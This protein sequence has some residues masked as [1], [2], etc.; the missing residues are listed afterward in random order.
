VSDHCPILVQIEREVRIPQRQPRRQYKILWERESDLAERV[1]AA[2]EDAGQK[3]DLADIMKGL[4][5]VMDTLQ[6]WSKRRFGN[7]LKEL[8]KARKRLELLK[9][10][11]ADQREIRQ[12]SDQLQELLYR[13]ELLWLQR[14]RVTWLKEGDRNT[15]FFHQRAV[16][17]A[18][19]NKIK[20]LKDSE[21]VWQ[22][23]PTDMERMATSY[24]QEL[25]T[26]DP[27]LNSDDLIAM[28]PEKVTEAMNMDLCKDFTEEEISD[29]L[30]QIGPLKAPGVD[31]FPARF[32]QR[33]WSTLKVEVIN[34]VRLFF[35]HRSYAP[36]CE[37]DGHCVDT[38]N[39]PT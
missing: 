15:K 8:G 30:F 31:G 21:G 39:G 20:R 37:R 2:W 26:R 10:N 9:I 5:G 17:R 1:A 29:A 28:I 24:F 11:N 22:D 23:S 4:D 19:K 36:W 32:Y 16:W 34:A 18:R 33:N 38:E 14:S 6:K 13:E 3:L 7:I 25:F 12:A 27:S 35:C